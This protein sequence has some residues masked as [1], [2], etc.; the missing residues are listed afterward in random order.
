M[1]AITPRGLYD[2]EITILSDE[3]SGMILSDENSGMT[4]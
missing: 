4:L 2:A 3:D 1:A